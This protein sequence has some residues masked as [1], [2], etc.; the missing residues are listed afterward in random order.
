MAF[1]RLDVILGSDVRGLVKGLETSNTVLNRTQK[2]MDETVDKSIKMGNTLATVGTK[3]SRFL[4]DVGGTL[5][6]IDTSS[7]DKLGIAS[8][9]NTQKLVN[10]LT[11]TVDIVTVTTTVFNTFQTVASVALT[12]I[13][14]SSTVLRTAIL[15]MTGPIG[16][17]LAAVSA[18]A[19][20]VYTNW[21]DLT[22]V[23]QRSADAATVF[24]RINK[25][26]TAEYATQSA[27]AQRLVS[28]VNDTTNSYKDRKSALNELQNI[29]QTYFGGLDIERTKQADLNA[30]LLAY[31]ENLKKGIQIRLLNQKIETNVTREITIDDKIKNFGKGD[32]F[33][34]T[35]DN[36]AQSA[37][38]FNPLGLV[39][40]LFKDNIN[41]LSTER[42]NLQ[43]ENQAIQKELQNLT[44]T[45]K[46]DA[47]KIKTSGSKI[48]DVLGDTIKQINTELANQKLFTAQGFQINTTETTN[49]LKILE[50]GLKKLLASGVKPTN[51]EFQKFK[52]LYE[53]LKPRA[54]L[55]DIKKIDVNIDQSTFSD[56]FKNMQSKYKETAEILKRDLVIPVSFE[57][58]TVQGIAESAQSAAAD[59]QDKF[60]KIAEITATV[61]NFAG[62]AA[63]I[64]K[65]FSDNGLEERRANLENYYEKE[66][67]LIEGSQV[68]EFRKQKAL[69]DLEKKTAAERRKI[70]NQEAVANKKKAIFDSII[71]TAV[72]VTSALARGGPILASITA[73][74]GL[75]Q[76]AAIAAAPIP[77]LAKGGIAYG[78]S[79]VNVGEYSGASGNP[80]VIAPLDRLSS[81]LSGVINN[82]LPQRSGGSHVLLSSVIRGGD[83]HQI[84][85]LEDYY[86]KRIR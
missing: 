72:A 36:L 2:T 7:L 43:K 3:L 17:G 21:E 48:K 30:Q 57:L 1:G 80:E 47:A 13:A 22:S 35:T 61:G 58:R 84:G 19:V 4:G 11:N 68:P 83:I 71:N 26:V 75:A 74:L 85:V 51:V 79:I 86:S 18:A 54:D 66:K 45:F 44:P 69:A 27:Q 34:R 9:V 76:T 64:F 33:K 81:I 42:S 77:K 5:R 78:N 39:V 6:S 16:I 41:D 23:F 59:L 20:A 28:V 40:N 82:I 49:S 55:F 32:I 25:E 29:S 60:S 67:A 8:T 56:A 52:Q 62:Q 65:S 46:V 63:N 73:G 31:N 12:K 53:T 14:A 10:G 38:A 15:A 37:R 70:A 50:S 24:N